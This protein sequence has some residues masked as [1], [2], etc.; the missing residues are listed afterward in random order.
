MHLQP[1]GLQPRLGKCHKQKARSKARDQNSEL[2]E[3]THFGAAGHKAQD[4]S[5][6]SVPRPSH[7]APP[8]PDSSARGSGPRG[9]A[10]TAHHP[11]ARP[12]RCLPPSP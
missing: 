11:L 4:K 9:A 12:R 5:L 8:P 2:R 3:M 10:N 7:A 6:A 1:I